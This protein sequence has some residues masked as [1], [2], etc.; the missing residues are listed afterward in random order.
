[1]TQKVY[2]GIDDHTRT[3]TYAVMDQAGEVLSRGTVRTD[4]RKLRERLMILNGER[5]VA[6][7]NGTRGAWLYHGLQDVCDTI[8][9]AN[10]C[11]T[12]KYRETKN[13]PIDAA[14]LANL[15]RM[16]ALRPVYVHTREDHRALKEGVRCYEQINQDVVRTKNR[17]KAVFLSVGIEC[18]GPG[19]YNRKTRKGWLERLP[20]PAS[21]RRVR[22]LLEEL[23]RLLPLKKK[24]EEQMV[25]AARK[26]KREYAILR[27]VP[28]IGLISGARL[29]GHVGTPGR[30]RHKRSFWKACGLAVVTRS[31]AD[32]RVDPETGEIREQR[33]VR[34]RGLN[35]DY[36]RAYKS[37]FKEAVHHA[38]RSGV[39]KEHY[40]RRIKAGMRES[41]ARLTIARKISAATLA[42]WQKGEKFDAEK[43]KPSGA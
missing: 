41:L 37:I 4:I 31:S 34:T 22:L 5:H 14:E 9:V 21:R 1:M 42:C 12:G 40:D 11:G 7:E 15:L 33:R 28:G 26:R 27:S 13:D 19:L 30:F 32:Y 18:S 8:M 6:I 17:L 25:K 29:L 43:M 36:N 16:G 24:A 2:I 20:A 10:L 35:Q 23:D 3:C 38:I 39:F